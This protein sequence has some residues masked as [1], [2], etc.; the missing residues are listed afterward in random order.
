MVSFFRMVAW[1]MRKCGPFVTH[2]DLASI[3]DSWHRRIPKTAMKAFTSEIQD[4]LAYV[5]ALRK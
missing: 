1:T 3:G 5:L 4:V 2:A